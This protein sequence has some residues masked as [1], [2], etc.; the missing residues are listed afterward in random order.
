MPEEGKEFQIFLKQFYIKGFKVQEAAET[1]QWVRALAPKPA[2]PVFKFQH[3]GESWTW[4]Q[5]LI[6]PG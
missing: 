2:G 5:E 3:S 6:T 4:L 1:A